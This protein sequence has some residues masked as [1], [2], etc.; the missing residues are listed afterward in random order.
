MEDAWRDPKV[1]RLFLR[2]LRQ[3]KRIVGEAHAI[4]DPAEEDVK[5]IE[6]VFPYR[7]ANNL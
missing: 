4:Q 3:L 1:W 7:H 6:M 2:G 5:V